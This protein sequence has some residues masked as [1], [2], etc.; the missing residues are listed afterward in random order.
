MARAGVLLVE[1]CV[2]FPAA[3]GFVRDRELAPSVQVRYLISHI[4]LDSAFL[5]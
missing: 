1:A 4:H 2:R 3:S 5:P